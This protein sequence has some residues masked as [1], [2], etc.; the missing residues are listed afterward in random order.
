M[1]PAIAIFA[2]NRPESLRR[3]LGSLE[4]CSG[5]SDARVTIFIDGP[6]AERD[7]AAVSQTKAVAES[8][9]RDHWEIRA[10][11][12]NKGLRRSIYDG[13]SD[14][15]SRHGHATILEDDLVLSTGAL[16]YFGE[17][18]RRYRDEDRVRSVCG[19][20][21]EHP[22]LGQDNRAFFLPFAHPWGWATWDRAW[23]QYAYDQPTLPEE[24]IGSDSF[25]RFFNVNG[26]MD[27]A[28]LLDLGQRGKVDSWFIRWHQSIFFSGGLSLFPS[29]RYVANMGVGRGGTHASRLNPYRLLLGAEPPENDQ[30]PAWPAR[31]EPDF[32]A[33][34]LMRDSRD[35]RAQRLIAKLGRY[36]RL[37]KRS[38]PQRN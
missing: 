15:C 26:L 31:I 17:A 22:K 4:R 23:A 19:Y 29:R 30:Q 9:A 20:T 14:V 34:D 5:F 7:V 11:T 8:V 1:T 2:Y 16:N 24:L 38:K 25:R 18:L 27:A 33:M 36:K 35:A 32:L 37:M 28:D 21:Y 12:A 6:R 13:V 3:L 10:S